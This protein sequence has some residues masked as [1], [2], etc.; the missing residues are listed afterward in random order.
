MNV[1]RSDAFAADHDLPTLGRFRSGLRSGIEQAAVCEDDSGGRLRRGLEKLSSIGHGVRLSA[2]SSRSRSSLR[3]DDRVYE[4]IRR[5][6]KTV[7]E[8]FHST[9]NP[10]RALF[11]RSDRH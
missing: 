8:R 4:S 6:P 5:H 1:N 11:R 10:K 3:L 9:G 7:A 2:K